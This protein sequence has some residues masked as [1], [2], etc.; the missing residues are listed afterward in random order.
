MLLNYRVQYNVEIRREVS[1]C[2]AQTLGRAAGFISIC[3]LFGQLR[4]VISCVNNQ[5]EVDRFQQENW[6]LFDL[7]Y[8]ET[9]DLFHNN[10]VG[11]RCWLRNC[12]MITSRLKSSFYKKFTFNDD[13]MIKRSA[14]T[15]CSLLDISLN[16]MQNRFC[17]LYLS[18][19]IRDFLCW[20]NQLF[21]SN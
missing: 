21:N 2:V 15:Q 10:S 11:L 1:S 4:C 16:W 9:A 14:I 7:F 12:V 13:L 5:N 3:R 17:N 20:F 6:Q 19:L 18:E 8:S